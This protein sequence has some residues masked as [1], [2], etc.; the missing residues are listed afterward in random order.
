M[1]WLFACLAVL[2]MVAPAMAGEDPYIAIVGND[3][4][5]ANSFYFSPK[6]TQFLYNQID[7]AVDV[8]VKGTAPLPTQANFSFL[9]PMN[10][11]GG[12]G[13]GIGG[14]SCE[15]FFAQT[16]A[17]QPEICDVIN[18]DG[19]GSQHALP[20]F[21]FRGLFTAKTPAGNA[22]W[23]EWWVRLPKKPS[24]EINIILQCGVVKPNA[25]AVYGFDAVLLCA[26]EA[27]ERI[28][29]GTCVRQEVDPGVSPVNNTAL[30]KITALVYPGPY[31]DFKPFN[32]TAFKNPSS[33]TLTFDPVTAAMS[34][35]TNSQI[36]D[37]SSN[38]R[39]VLKTC[40]DK[41]IVTKLPVTGQINALGQEET[42]LEAG[43]IIQV[44]MEVPRQNSVD[45]YCHA[46]SLRLAGVGEAPF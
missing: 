23:Y 35:N 29:A 18:G 41:T 31:N 8:C 10:V 46:Q 17:I 19:A 6:H 36:L 22:G 45:I 24:G 37:G 1:K 11:P 38:S 2:L 3:M 14:V 5:A 42:D 20:P 39:V 7:F 15:S 28:G 12:T 40:M 44:K 27:G 33:Y 16:P 34:N 9:R 30:P 43:D 13:P 4:T 26:A 25:F 32:L 21:T